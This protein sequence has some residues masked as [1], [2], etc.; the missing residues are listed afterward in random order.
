MPGQASPLNM[1]VFRDVA[2]A[3]VGAP[4]EQ[5]DVVHET[6]RQPEFAGGLRAQGTAHAERDRGRGRREGRRRRQGRALGR[7]AG[8]LHVRLVEVVIIVVNYK[9]EKDKRT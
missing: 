5:V 4:A 6:G 8:L 9:T 7:S 1:T 2:G 3:L